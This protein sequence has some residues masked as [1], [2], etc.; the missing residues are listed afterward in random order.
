MKYEEITHKV[1]G[2]S[3]EVHRN[4]EPG[5]QEYICHR[6]LANELKLQGIQFEDGY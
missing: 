5:F 1:I 4:L 2:C 3:M 6:A